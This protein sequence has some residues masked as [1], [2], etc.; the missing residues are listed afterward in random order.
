MRAIF[1]FFT[2][3]YNHRHCQKSFNST[4]HSKGAD[5]VEPAAPNMLPARHTA[6]S[7]ARGS[8]S[9]NTNET[10]V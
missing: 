6:R 2:M 7:T 9:E 8:R 1:E 3:F 10:R 4:R 5:H